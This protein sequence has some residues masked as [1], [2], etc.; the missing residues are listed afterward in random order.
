MSHGW[1]RALQRTLGDSYLFVWL[2]VRRRSSISTYIDGVASSIDNKKSFATLS[3]GCQW[4][5]FKKQDKINSTLMASFVRPLW[6]Q[7]CRLASPSVTNEIREWPSPL[8]GIN[9]AWTA[10]ARIL[11]CW[12][13]SQPFGWVRTNSVLSSKVCHNSTPLACV[14]SM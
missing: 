6:T 9:P 5:S 14:S 12:A 7:K 13:P 10:A 8:L 4:Y 1:Q 3:P 2:A 11:H